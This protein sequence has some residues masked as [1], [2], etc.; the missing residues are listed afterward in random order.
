MSHEILQQIKAI[1]LELKTKVVAAKDEVNVINEFIA[2]RQ[3]LVEMLFSAQHV[4]W[5]NDN[6]AAVG[7]LQQEIKE[8]DQLYYG[9]LDTIKNELQK[10]K[11]NKKGVN[12]YKK[13][14]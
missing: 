6:R 13:H 11:Q 12:A 10:L 9:E 3:D 7:L 1:N 8:I 5:T 14:L 4:Q 2:R